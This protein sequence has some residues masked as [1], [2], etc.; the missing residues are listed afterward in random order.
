MFALRH[1]LPF[2][3]LR[4]LLA[5]RVAVDAAIDRPFGEYGRT[6][7]EIARLPF[8]RQLIFVGVVLDQ[9]PAGFWKYQKYADDTGW[10]PGPSCVSQPQRLI[11][12]PPPNTSWISRTVNAT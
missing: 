3:R 11:C 6:R 5:T 7:F 12:M 8:G 9:P 4:V 2:R 10:R 1:E